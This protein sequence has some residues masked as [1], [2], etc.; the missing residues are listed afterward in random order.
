MNL[1]GTSITIYTLKKKLSKKFFLLFYRFA[2][3]DL[4]TD[5]LYFNL[6]KKFQL[7]I[8]RKDIH[9]YDL[10][11]II[12]DLFK[13]KNTLKEEKLIFCFFQHLWV[14]TDPDLYFEPPQLFIKKKRIFFYT[15]YEI[16]FPSS[17]ISYVKIK[18]YSNLLLEIV[19]ETQEN[20]DDFLQ[21]PQT[22]KNCLSENKELILPE[23][24]RS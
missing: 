10:I 8:K 1:Q 17:I 18:D 7:K 15:K 5:L 24:N 4:F 23:F 14:Q 22:L 12:I 3:E 19:S 16:N 13:K 21:F 20:V 9:I 2:T 6:C 11:K